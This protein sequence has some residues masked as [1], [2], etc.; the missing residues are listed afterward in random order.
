MKFSVFLVNKG[1]G[2]AKNQHVELWWGFEARM[3]NVYESCALN[4]KA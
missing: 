4:N 3:E 1:K 2:V